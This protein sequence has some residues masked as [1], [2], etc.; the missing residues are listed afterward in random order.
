MFKQNNRRFHLSLHLFK[1]LGALIAVS[2]SGCADQDED[3]NQDGS[4]IN[5]GDSQVIVRYE[6]GVDTD[7]PPDSAVADDS[8][9]D[10]SIPEILLRRDAQTEASLA[11]DAFVEASLPIDGSTDAGL[12]RIDIHFDYRYDSKQSFQDPQRQAL[13]QAAARAWTRFIVSE[14]ENIPA[15]TPV[16]ARNPE[17]IDQSGVIFTLEYDIDDVAIVTGYTEID[18]PEGVLGWSSLSITTRDM[19]AALVDRLRERYEGAVFQPWIAQISFDEVENWF[20]DPTPDSDEDIPADRIDFLSTATHEI[21]HVLGFAT[22]NAFKALIDG[23]TFIGPRAMAVYGGPVPLESDLNH[24]LRDTEIN[25]ETPVMERGSPAGQR[26][27][28]TELDLAILE[29]IG[30]IIDWS[31]L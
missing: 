16:R 31:V 4:V 10:A 22:S 11:A 6:G 5:A 25:G 23:E 20:Y 26:K 19:D 12:E 14:F 9:S 8:F 1:L 17:H 15:G 28:P 30:Y 21:G 3:L 2:H 18:G 27:R 24:I 7:N 13:M 29:D